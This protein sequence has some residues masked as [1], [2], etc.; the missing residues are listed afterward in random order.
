MGESYFLAEGA[1][2]PYA[3]GQQRVGDPG[4]VHLR[5]IIVSPALRGAGVGRSLCTQPIAEA[6]RFTRA[7]SVTLRVYRDNEAAVALYSSLGFSRV[8]VKSYAQVVFMSVRYPLT[9]NVAEKR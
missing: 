9:S 6:L 8:E 2:A 4:A 3:F 7:S 1:D 5:R